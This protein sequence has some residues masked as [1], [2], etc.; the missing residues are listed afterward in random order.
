MKKNIHFFLLSV[1]FLAV[2]SC[3]RPVVLIDRRINDNKGTYV[4]R[5]INELPGGSEKGSGLRIRVFHPFFKMQKGGE[6]SITSVSLDG[7]NYSLPEDGILK[8]ETKSGKMDLQVI[9]YSY[10]VNSSFKKTIKLERKRQ[11][12]ID[13]YLPSYSAGWHEIIN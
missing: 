3:V 6:H 2:G 7:V 9:V 8:I 10:P 4:I 11:Y 12:I 5:E 13:I 1:T